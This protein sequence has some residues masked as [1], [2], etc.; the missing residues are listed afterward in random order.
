MILYLKKAAPVNILFK[1]IYCKAL[2]LYASATHYETHDSY[3]Y[4]LHFSRK[5]SLSISFGYFT[6]YRAYEISVKSHNQS[7]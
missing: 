5:Y 1:S 6:Y 7:A 2:E 4:K 3:F